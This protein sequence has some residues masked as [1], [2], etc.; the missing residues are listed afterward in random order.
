MSTLVDHLAQLAAEL[1]R[2][3]APVTRHWRPGADPEAVSVRVRDAG[4]HPHPDVVGWYSWHDGT[5]LPP[6]VT[7]PGG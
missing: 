4:A 1:T 6:S 2:L 7:P 3:D 5:D